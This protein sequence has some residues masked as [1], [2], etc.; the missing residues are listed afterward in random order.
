MGLFCSEAKVAGIIPARGGSKGL[1]RK[2]LRLLNGLPLI[3]YTIRAAL[4]AR[5]LDVVVVTTEDEEIAAVAETHGARVIRRPHSLATD[6][7]QNTA[8]V[9]HALGLLGEDVTHVVLLQPTSPLRRSADIDH[10]VELLLKSAASSVMSV[11]PVDHHPGKALRIGEG[12]EAIPFTNASDMESRR[13]DLPRVYRQNGA[14]YAIGRDDF[15]T[16]DRFILS[17]CLVHMM[18]A[19]TSIDID[20]EFDLVFAELLL[21]KLT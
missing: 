14:V 19:E 6:A 16:R 12:G 5:F 9:R 3:A 4:E 8:V 10:C 1:P 2:N 20:S 21:N 18:P 11:T 7:V 15:V 13:Q 17:P